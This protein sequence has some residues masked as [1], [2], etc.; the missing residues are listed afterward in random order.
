MGSCGYTDSGEENHSFTDFIS[1]FWNM[2]PHGHHSSFRSKQKSL[3]IEALKMSIQPPFTTSLHKGQ[4]GKRTPRR[5]C[6]T[7]QWPS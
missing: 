4:K 6:P 5:N 3:H 7:L 2:R 1:Y